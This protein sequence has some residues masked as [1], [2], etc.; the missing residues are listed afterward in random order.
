MHAINQPTIT[1]RLL[2]FRQNA[3]WPLFSKEFSLV[4][5]RPG[6][7]SVTPVPQERMDKKAPDELA[8]GPPTVWRISVSLTDGVVSEL[9]LE[10]ELGFCQEGGGKGLPHRRKS[11]YSHGGLDRHGW[12]GVEGGHQGSPRG[13]GGNPEGDAERQ[14]GG[15][16]L[17]LLAVSVFI[18]S[19]SVSPQEGR[20][21]K[22]T[23]AACSLCFPWAWLVLVKLFF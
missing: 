14:S 1:K 10:G 4:E 15:R 17:F 12:F 22:A 13:V 21:G 3:T 19:V 7:F 23:E 16:K 6:N 18:C 20:Q 2:S 9:G 11:M 8:G 5:K